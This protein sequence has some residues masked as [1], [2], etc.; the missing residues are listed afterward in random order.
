MQVVIDGIEYTPR[1]KPYGCNLGQAISAKR[2]IL[3][4]TYKEMARRCG[5]SVTTINDIEH[6]A[7]PKLDTAAKI[8]LGLGLD[9]GR[10]AET[11][12]KNP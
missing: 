10:L 5:V 9:I 11:V 2:R 12:L 1:A 7:M 6:G 3:G 4:I 8:A